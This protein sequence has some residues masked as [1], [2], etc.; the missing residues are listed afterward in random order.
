MDT[1]AIDAIPAGL[2]EMEPGPVL[3]GFLASIDVTCV[4]G[5][6]R[7]VVV[8]AHQ[9]MASHHAAQVYRSMASVTD[10]ICEP[11][12]ECTA[13]SAAE[14]AAAEIR[15]ALHLTRRAADA[16]LSFALDLRDRLPRLAA[17]LE[18]GKIDPRRARTIERG[19]THLADEAARG[20]VD[21]IAE[22]ASRLTT[23]QLAVR[24]RRL[25]IEAD[26]DEAEARYAESVADRRVV[27][28]PNETGTAN[29]FGLNLPPHRVALLTRRINR[30]ARSLR[31]SGESRTMDQLRADVY[32]D[33][34]AGKHGNATSGGS[35]RGVVD[36]RVD[37][38]TLAGLT[39]HPGD[40]GGYGP[41]ISDIARQMA[42]EG[43]RCEWRY[44]VADTATGQPI[45]TGTTS[46]RPTAAQ[47]RAIESRDVTCIFPGC[48]MP[49]MDCDLDHRIPWA[50]GGPTTVRHLTP[51]CRYDHITVRHDAGW[52][53]IRLPNGDYRWT[54]RL[55]HTY[56]TTRAPP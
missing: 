41:V 5:Y 8:R 39:D 45:H 6:D 54:S 34:L 17:M 14:Y 10:A 27:M 29:L 49:A 21:R 33:L 4:S 47:R 2:D 43:E 25:C 55:G 40:L 3:A 28:E 30:I 52:T 36:I 51:V 12:E 20:V 26:P 1:S 53:Y 9:R 11:G 48:R 50:Q 42:E 46:R 19:T 22:I 23:G 15:A 13:E 16:E 44:T 38:D 7:I 56:T 18:A 24:I 35:K 32:L 37:L 31:G